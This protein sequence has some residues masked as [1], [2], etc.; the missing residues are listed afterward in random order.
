MT[1]IEK[2]VCKKKT[3]DPRLWRPGRWVS[4]AEDAYGVLVSFEEEHVRPLSHRTL[5]I[6]PEEGACLEKYLEDD[7]LI[8]ICIVFKILQSKA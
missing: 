5:E 8:V 4:L 7:R 1:S 2:T 3:E 6:F